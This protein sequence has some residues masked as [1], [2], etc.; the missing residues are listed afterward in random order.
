[1]Q[2][3][4]FAVPACSQRAI[5]FSW[6]GLCISGFKK[7]AFNPLNCFYQYGINAIKIF[8]KMTIGDLE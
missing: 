4:P 7:D 3:G 1:M 5:R 6:C 2:A 8:T